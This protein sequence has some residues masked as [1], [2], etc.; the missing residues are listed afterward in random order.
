[1]KQG[2]YV[3]YQL[4]IYLA[5]P[6]QIKIGKLGIFNFPSGRYIYTG[7]AHRHLEARV[8]RHLCQN[9][10]LRWHIDY[11][12][13]A[14]GASVARVERFTQA[15]CE[16]NQQS[17]GRVLIAGFGSSDCQAGCGSHLK[18]IG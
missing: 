11:L 6:T 10:C 2:N 16:I 13:A 17:P 15:E 9:K 12:L 1:M 8:A 18:Y 3:T 5:T 14:S 4:F 7:S